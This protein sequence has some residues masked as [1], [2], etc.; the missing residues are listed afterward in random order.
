MWVQQILARGDTVVATCRNPEAS[1]ELN[2]LVAGSEGSTVLP[3]DVASETSIEAFMELLAQHE[4]RTGRMAAID[5]LVHN[6]GISNPTHPIDPVASATAAAMRACYETNA[7]APLMLTQQFLPRL[8][9]GSAK[10]IFFVSTA[11]AS[12]QGTTSGGSISYRSSKAAL[13][14][15]GRCLAG[16]HGIGTEDNLAVTLCHPGWVDTDMG[17]A[18]DRTPPVKPADSVAGML[19]IIENMGAQSKADFLDFQ[20]KEMK[21]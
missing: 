15:V 14:M 16:E 8:R 3:L 18:G 13:N 20:G 10:K 1:K 7:L 4:V 2:E 17:S 19:T 21:W 11:M 12:M 5:V 6:A 9:A